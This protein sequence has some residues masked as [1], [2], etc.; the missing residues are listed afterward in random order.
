MASD[1]KNVAQ[2]IMTPQGLII[3][4]SLWVLRRPKNVLSLRF[5]ASAFP[6]HSAKAS[7]STG[8]KAPSWEDASAASTSSRSDSVVSICDKVFPSTS[9]P[10][11]SPV[12]IPAFLRR[13]WSVERPFPCRKYACSSCWC[14][15]SKH[16]LVPA[17][18]ALRQLA[19]AHWLLSSWCWAQKRWWLSTSSSLQSWTAQQGCPIVTPSQTAGCILTNMQLSL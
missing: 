14:I 9:P 11:A 16:V 6:S 5:P 3:S 12:E 15:G 18:R 19:T 1:P 2:A 4:C 13:F 17:L 7:S 8:I 10:Q